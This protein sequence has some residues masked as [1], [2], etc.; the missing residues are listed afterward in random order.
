MEQ[1]HGRFFLILAADVV[2]KYAPE[3][4]I[5]VHFHLDRS[6]R[7]CTGIPVYLY[8]PNV[9]RVTRDPFLATQVDTHPDKVGLLFMLQRRRR[10]LQQQTIASATQN[11]VRST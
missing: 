4:R 11:D 9:Y 1:H 8:D 2:T 3:N 7:K 6:G 5:F 10:S